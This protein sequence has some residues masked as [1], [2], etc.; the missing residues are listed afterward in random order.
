MPAGGKIYNP[1]VKLLTELMTNV[2][3]TKETAVI[4]STIRAGGRE[5]VRWKFRNGSGKFQLWGEEKQGASE[6]EIKGRIEFVHKITL[7]D[8]NL[9]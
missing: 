1:C 2:S 8:R 7:D 9:F 5:K 3:R 6:L 4:V